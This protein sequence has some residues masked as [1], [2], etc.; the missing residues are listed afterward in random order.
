VSRTIVLRTEAQASLAWSLL[1]VW[2]EQV[3]AGKP[4]AVTVF[5]WKAKRSLEQNSRLHALLG[6]IAEQATVGGRKFT[7]EVWKQFFAQ[8]FIGSEDISL[9]N[10]KVIHRP[11]STTTLDAAAFGDFMQRIESYAVS[12]LGVRFHA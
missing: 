1:K 7:L 2:P 10:G 3:A 9:P 12:E 4:L 8:Q 5:E 11:V 6:E